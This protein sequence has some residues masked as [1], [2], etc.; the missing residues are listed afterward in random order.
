MKEVL[1]RHRQQSGNLGTSVWNLPGGEKH[2][3]S[4]VFAIP[5]E[6]NGEECL[7][8]LKIFGDKEHSVAGKKLNRLAA[9]GWNGSYGTSAFF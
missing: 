3:N 8:Q 5:L 7:C 1:Q 4:M 6:V 2:P 9:V